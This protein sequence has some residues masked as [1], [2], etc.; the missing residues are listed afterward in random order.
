MPRNSQN[1]VEA[2]RSQTISETDSFTPERHA[3]FHSHLPGGNVRARRGLQ[4]WSRRQ[5]LKQLDSSL[6]LTGFDCVPERL[7]ALDRQVYTRSLCRLST[8]IPIEDESFNVIL[9]GEFIE[10]VPPAFYGSYL[11][12]GDKW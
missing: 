5:M 11:V 1:L 12:R 10:H 6:E 2:N 3:Q 4:H 7:A 8:A 9:G